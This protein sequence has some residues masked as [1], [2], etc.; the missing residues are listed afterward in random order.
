MKNESSSR[1]HKFL[2]FFADLN[3]GAKNIKG[4][5]SLILFIVFII[6]SL[7]MGWINLGWWMFL[8]PILL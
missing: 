7:S 2:A 4:I 3:E 5:L 8:L 1:W 6:H